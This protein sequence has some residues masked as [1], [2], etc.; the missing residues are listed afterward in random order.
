MAVLHI[1][2]KDC[3]NNKSSKQIAILMLQ[4]II[5]KESDDLQN[6]VARLYSKSYEELKDILLMWKALYQIQGLLLCDADKSLEGK[7]FLLNFFVMLYLGFGS[8]FF[9]FLQSWRINNKNLYLYSAPRAEK[10]AFVWW[11][12]QLE[13]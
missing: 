10:H 6:T 2:Y 7:F 11:L 8:Y 5:D 4:T 1:Q 13:S 3:M 12:C 9:T